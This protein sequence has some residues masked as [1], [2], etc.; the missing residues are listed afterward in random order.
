MREIATGGPTPLLFGCAKTVS[1]LHLFEPLGLL[2]ERKQTPIGL[3]GLREK[4]WS[5]TV[6]AQFWHSLIGLDRV[7]TNS[8]ELAPW[9]NRY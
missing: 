8:W 4:Q 7:A 1:E 2:F 3:I 5:P 9:Q 6:F